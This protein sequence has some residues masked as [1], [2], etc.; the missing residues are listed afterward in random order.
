MVVPWHDLKGRSKVALGCVVEDGR[1]FRV[2]PGK[3]FFPSSR[4]LGKSQT[5]SSPHADI[6]LQS[7]SILSTVSCSRASP[8]D[9][10]AR[11]ASAMIVRRPEVLV[12]P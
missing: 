11:R 1:L 8:P 4:L 5:H 9:V 3:E 12:L 7:L 2:P 10:L 6:K